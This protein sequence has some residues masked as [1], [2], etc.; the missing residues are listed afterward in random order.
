M[1]TEVKLSVIVPVYNGE[2]YIDRAMESILGQTEAALEVVA[3]ND[4]SKDKSL[5]KLRGWEVKDSRV[6]VIDKENEGVSIARNVA[7]EAARGTYLTFLDVDDYL[8]SDAYSRVIAV[9][10]DTKAQACLC[11]F[12]DENEKQK[13]PV[14]LPWDTGTL[15]EKK[16]IWDQLIP[17]MIK[18]Y[19]EDGIEGNIFGSVWRLFLR[20]DVWEQTQVTFDA[21]LKIAEDF[22]FCIHLF[23]KLQTIGI[24]KEPLYHYIRWE[25]TTLSVYRKNHFKEGMENQ[26]RLKAFLIENG[27]YEQLKKRFLGSYIDVCI[28]SMVN[29]VRPGAPSFVQCTR[30]LKEVVDEIARDGIYEEISLVPLTKN[31]KLVLDLIKKK[32]VCSILFFTKLRQ[33]KKRK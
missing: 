21:G 12:F 22:D 26:R 3:V 30:E 4:G 27:R 15:L 18:V 31:Q 25:Q 7:M 24:V 6:R 16:D 23:S 20:K 17:W 9:L 2:A 1:A 13:I 19:P 8:E 5:E 28:G 29:F 14:L 10:E 11:S 32:R 33:I